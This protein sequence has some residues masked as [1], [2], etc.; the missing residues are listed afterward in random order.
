MLR[1]RPSIQLLGA[2]GRS[3]DDAADFGHEDFHPRLREILGECVA[4]R[5]GLGL[6]QPSE[7]VELMFSPCE[8]TGDARLKCRS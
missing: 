1:R 6:Y 8:R 3:F 2:H 7:L 5:I 4:E